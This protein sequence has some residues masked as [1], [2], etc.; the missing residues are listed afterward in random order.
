[1][2][3]G[4]GEEVPLAQANLGALL[5]RQGEFEQA[6]EL[7]KQVLAS[8]HP[9]NAPPAADLLGNLL[10]EQKDIAGAQTAY[11]TAIDSDHRWASAARGLISPC[12]S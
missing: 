11:Q 2:V 7:L 9:E 4:P 5:M 3:T 12:C 8:G 6:R 1:M 10:V